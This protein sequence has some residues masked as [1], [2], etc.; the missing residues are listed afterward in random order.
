MVGYG[1]HAPWGVRGGSRSQPVQQLTT[2]VELT[3]LVE[4]SSAKCIT[5]IHDA[6][7]SVVRFTE[8]K[9]P[10]MA[11]RYGGIGRYQLGG[12]RWVVPNPHLAESGHTRRMLIR[13]NPR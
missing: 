2:L 13:V 7:A 4:L 12:L 9:S 3:K 6:L 11:R 10:I 1:A 8:L 5:L